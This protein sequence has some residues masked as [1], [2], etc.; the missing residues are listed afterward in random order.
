LPDRR[1]EQK[2]D[3]VVVMSTFSNST[4]NKQC[5][6]SNKIEKKLRGCEVQLLTE[7]KEVLFTEWGCFSAGRGGMI[8]LVVRHEHSFVYIAHR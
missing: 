3:Y 6:N 4:Q 2:T 1:P 5:K 7:K 8:H